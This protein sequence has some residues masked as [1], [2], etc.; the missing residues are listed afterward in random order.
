MGLR[1]L[2]RIRS[3]PEDTNEAAK[4]AE[5]ESVWKQAVSQR[6]KFATLS[7]LKAK[8]TD[9]ITASFRLC[10]P[11]QNFKG[12]LN[13]AHRVFVLSAD[14][15]EERTGKA[16]LASSTPAKADLEV[17]CAFLKTVPG[18]TDFVVVF[19][20]RNRASRRVIQDALS[21][22]PHSC[23]LFI[24]YTG[25]TVR[26]GRTRKTLLASPTVEM[27]SVLL[28][29]QASK[30][31]LQKREHSNACNESSTWHSTY[32]GVRFRSTS[33]IPLIVR[34]EKAAI[35][36]RPED[37]DLPE[38]W[39]EKHGQAVPLFWQESK[40]IAFWVALLQ[41]LRAKAVFDLSPG[42]GGCAEAAMSM[43]L[44]YH[45]LC[46]SPSVRSPAS[47]LESVSK[48]ARNAVT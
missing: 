26:A 10:G 12:V 33:E 28:P 32:S 3:N 31:Q 38:G 41:D 45:G 43:G 21:S 22:A 30:V 42:S 16:W 35:L 40:P 46:G 6:K 5:R 8:T 20:G 36:K 47:E 48:R 27:A 13:E 17:V 19:D 1:Q 7:V 25:K 23:E 11:V 15:L 44:L 24:L 34:Q 39:P 14:M 18:P 2:A 4:V 37:E 9:G 29:V